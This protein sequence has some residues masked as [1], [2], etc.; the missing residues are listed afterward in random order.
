MLLAIDTATQTISVALHDGQ[1]LLAEQTWLAGN[2]HTTVLA[3]TIEQMVAA[4]G[5]RLDQLTALAVSTGPGSYTG[6][7]V[8]VALAKGLAAVHKLPLVGVSA[9]DTLA[10]GTPYLNGGLVVL[11]Q[12]GRSRLIVKAY[13]WR[14]GRWASHK[15]EEPQLLDWEDLLAKIDGPAFLSG[16][17]TADGHALIQSAQ[18]NGAPV[19]IVAAAFRLRRAGFLAEEALARLR[20]SADQREFD[21]ARLLPVYIKTK[22]VPA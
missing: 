5:A 20:E 18:A 6:L 15:S 11:L 1:N 10:A 9:L 19:H 22:D 16:E 17:I 13:R 4:S 14:K 2:Q 12:A 21:A 7:R 3:A 8:G